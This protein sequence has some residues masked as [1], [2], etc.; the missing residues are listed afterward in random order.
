[1]PWCESDLPLLLVSSG[2]KTTLHLSNVPSVWVCPL[3]L[4]APL[5]EL[6]I[7]DVPEI[8]IAPGALVHRRTDFTLNV[9]GVSEDLDVPEK[10]FSVE[11]TGV[12]NGER[13]PVIEGIVE[14]SLLLEVRILIANAKSVTFESMSV[15]APHVW[16]EVRE[17]EAL[18]MKTNAVTALSLYSR[19]SALIV[20]SAQSFLM[21]THAATVKRLRV[22]HTSTL[23]LREESVEMTVPGGEVVLSHIEQVTLPERSIIVGAGAKLELTNVSLTTLGHRAI[24]SSSPL[25]SSSLVGVAVSGP[26]PTPICLATRHLVLK[27][28]TAA[29]G[30]HNTATACIMFSHTLEVDKGKSAPGVVLAKTTSYGIFADTHQFSDPSC[31]LCNP[32]PTGE[33]GTLLNLFTGDLMLGRGHTSYSPFILTCAHYPLF[34]S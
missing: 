5:Q 23:L 28:M 4:G 10:A 31:V 20:S 22:T 11:Y 17:T 30:E 2:E 29:M 18:V 1:M 12:Q 15:S 25:F 9:T 14:D 16:V 19:D 7:T 32:R 8:R 34:L 6:S 27:N 26:A 13:A 33:R 24:Y 21:G 3:S